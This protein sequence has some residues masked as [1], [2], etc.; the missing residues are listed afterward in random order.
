MIRTQAHMERPNEDTEK[1][2]VI[3]KPRREASGNI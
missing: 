3:F 1:K 2:T